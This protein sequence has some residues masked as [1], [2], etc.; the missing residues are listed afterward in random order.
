MK[1]PPSLFAGVV[2][3]VLVLHSTLPAVQASGEDL[4]NS[5]PLESLVLAL[6]LISSTHARPATGVVLAGAGPGG[7][8]LVMVPASF[9]GAG[10]E[11]IVLDGGNDIL[12]NG[13]ATRTVARSA[14]AGVAVLEVEGLT[15]P[16]VAI[17]GDAWTGPGDSSHVFAAWPAAG[18]LVEGAALT[19][20]SFR[21]GESLPGVSGPLFD[22]CGYLAAMYVA[23]DDGRLRGSGELLPGV[24]GCLRNS[25]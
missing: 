3:L 1:L 2:F 10:D 21:S 23:D 15:R 14:E 22:R 24:S 16:G 8:S 11:I 13:R 17:A 12:R 18:A 4:N 19:L 25:A 5:V 20:Q 7:D 9:V 6:N